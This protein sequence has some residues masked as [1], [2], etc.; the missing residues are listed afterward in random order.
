MFIL[1]L[2]QGRVPVGAKYTALLVEPACF[3][4]FDRDSGISF[5]HAAFKVDPHDIL[6][7]TVP[8]ALSKTV[9]GTSMPV[10]SLKF[11]FVWK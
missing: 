8:K 4:Y 6:Y 7:P 1:I 11:C 5:P 10:S 3:T 9:S 2:K